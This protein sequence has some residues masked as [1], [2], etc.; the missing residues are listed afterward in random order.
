MEQ[1]TDE[2]KKNFDQRFEAQSEMI[3][4]VVH[5]VCALLVENFKLIFK[6]E[7]KKEID[8]RVISEKH[9][10]QQQITSLKQVNLQIQ[11]DLE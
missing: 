4:S 6:E 7:M 10:L 2:L 1:K 9:M 11:N 3:K 5:D 8:E